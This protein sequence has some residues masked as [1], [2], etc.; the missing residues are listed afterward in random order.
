MGEY[1]ES[2]QALERAIA[3]FIDPTIMAYEKEK[4]PNAQGHYHEAH[5]QLGRVLFENERDFSRAVSELEE[6]TRLDPENAR[7]YYYLGQ[8]IRA[9]VDRETLAKAEEALQTY[10]EKRAP[11]G[12][13]DE[14]RKFL[15][16]RMK[17]ASIEHEG[18]VQG[19]SGYTEQKA[20]R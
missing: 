12:N 9:M 4:D 10:L 16:S 11:L 14:V 17:G 19:F 15:G 13:E 20:T 1:D 2:I 18:R 6:A 7:A 5:Y 8:A 3:L